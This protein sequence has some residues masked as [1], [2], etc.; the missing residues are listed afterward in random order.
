MDTLTKM[1]DKANS[2]PST[3]DYS[4]YK[5]HFSIKQ[6]PQIYCSILLAVV[7]LPILI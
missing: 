1:I 5:N 7:H 3:V 4:T 6:I 2:V